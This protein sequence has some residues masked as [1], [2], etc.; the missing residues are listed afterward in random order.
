[1]QPKYSAVL[2]RLSQMDSYES[3]VSLSVGYPVRLYG[4]YYLSNLVS[5]VLLKRRVPD[6]CVYGKS[7]CPGT[8]RPTLSPLRK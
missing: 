7:P 4:Q 2:G 6:S 8:E 5:S 3:R 1:M